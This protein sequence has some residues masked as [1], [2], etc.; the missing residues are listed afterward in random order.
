[1]EDKVNLQFTFNFFI[2]LALVAST[3]LNL[4]HNLGLARTEFTG[5]V[6]Q[7][8][9]A[10]FSLLGAVAWLLFFVLLFTHGDFVLAK[11]T[12]LLGTN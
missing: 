5:L 6:E 2:I 9:Y 3:V 12:Q 8:V 11:F 10:F 4:M 1:M 7:A